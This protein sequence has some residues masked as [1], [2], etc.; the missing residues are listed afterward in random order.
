M[1]VIRVGVDLAKN[2]FQIH[3]VGRCEKVIWRR[4]LIRSE[5]IKVRMDRIEPGC[6]IGIEAYSGAYYW[7]RM[8][9]A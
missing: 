7:A 8:L 1:K 2:V 6:E 3:D 5:W 9:K 4:K